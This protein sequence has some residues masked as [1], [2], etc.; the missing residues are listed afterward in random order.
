MTVEHLFGILVVLPRDRCDPRWRVHEPDV[1]ND[2][3][4]IDSI[5]AAHV[6]I[7]DTQREMFRWIAQIDRDELW[8]GSGARDMAHWLCMRYDL[9]D[10]KARRWLVAAHALEHLPLISE[11]FSTGELGIDKVVELT[12]F[13]TRETERDL[14]SWARGGVLRRDPAQGGPGHTP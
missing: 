11:A 13:A 5:D 4:L 6:R 3:A 8:V 1:P 7:C 9:S 12:R 10:W 14:L 2:E